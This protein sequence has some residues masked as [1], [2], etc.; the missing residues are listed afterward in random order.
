[1]VYVVEE[2]D[3]NNELYYKLG[4]TYDMNGQNKNFSFYF[5]PTINIK[6]FSF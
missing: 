1:M 5:T 2:Y 4:K 3:E 6:N